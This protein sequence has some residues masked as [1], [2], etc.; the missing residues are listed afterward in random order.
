M[1]IEKKAEEEKEAEEEY[2]SWG[3]LIVKV[4]KKFKSEY[5][6]FGEYNIF[7]LALNNLS[8]SYLKFFA[9]KFP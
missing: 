5:C 7:N 9:D 8:L 6:C 4:V 2:D 1:D 3:N